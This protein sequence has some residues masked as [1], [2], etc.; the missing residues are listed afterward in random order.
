[1]EYFA[2]PAVTT[3]INNTLYFNKDL[4]A[5][6]K[7]ESPGQWMERYIAEVPGK[8]ASDQK[9]DGSRVRLEPNTAG[10]FTAWIGGVPLTDSNGVVQTYTKSQ[11]SQWIS[12]T[13]Q[14]ELS[15][16]VDQENSKKAYKAWNERVV[17]EYN[18]RNTTPYGTSAALSYLTSPGAYEYFRQQGALNKPVPE[19]IEIIKKKGK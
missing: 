11:I 4:P 7:D 15:T 9:M 13:Y 8:I 6:P 10:G 18:Q 2:N 16:K 12:S 5:V 17:K 1:V 14:T 19:L 3:K